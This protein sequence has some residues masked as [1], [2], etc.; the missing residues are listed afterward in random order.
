MLNSTLFS[1][2][3]LAAMVPA[4]LINLRADG[5]RDA[6][7]WSVLVIAVFGSLSWAVAQLGDSWH[8]GLSVATWLAISAS[9]IVFLAVTLLTAQAWRLTPLLLPYLLLLGIMATVWSQ[10]PGKPLPS[11]VPWGWMS[12]HIG[13]SILTFALLT[14]AAVAGLAVVLQERAL[15]RKRVSGLTHALP[16]IADGEALQ[17]RLLAAGE[18]VL[19]AGLL[20]GLATRYMSEASLFSLDHKTLLSTLCFVVIAILLIAHRRVGVR[21][22]RA[23]SYT[24]VAYLLL[25]LAYL[26]VKFVTDVLI[27]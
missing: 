6:V 13:L 14:V 1:L 10:A 9:L 21:G 17:L 11:A 4:S 18:T 15:K 3:A 19:G 12:V 27:S 22:R 7:Y 24:L 8:T 2:A 20:T 26:G 5:R 16:S 25:T 23:G